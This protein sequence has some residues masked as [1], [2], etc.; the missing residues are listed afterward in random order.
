MFL[1][2]NLQILSHSNHTFLK[3]TQIFC[4]F[5]FVFVWWNKYSNC[6]SHFQSAFQ[7]FLV[8][9]FPLALFFCVFC[10]GNTSYGLRNKKIWIRWYN[11]Q[12]KSLGDTA[13]GSGDIQLGGLCDIQISGLRNI[14]IGGSGDIQDMIQVIENMTEVTRHMV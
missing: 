14:Q 4:F 2:A 9:F 13:E 1:F 12:S 6:T 5:C 7:N 3:I 8:S 11:I 10:W